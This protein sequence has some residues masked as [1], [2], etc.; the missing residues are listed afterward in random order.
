MWTM[1]TYTRNNTEQDKIRNID[2]NIIPTNN[3]IVIEIRLLRDHI[4]CDN[5]KYQEDILWI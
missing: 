1:W 4:Y 5:S 2:R 3:A